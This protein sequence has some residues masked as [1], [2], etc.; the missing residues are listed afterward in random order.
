MAVG[1]SAEDVRLQPLLA[2]LLLV[3]RP[4]ILHERVHLRFLQPLE[5][6]FA[7]ARV[8]ELRQDGDEERAPVV[9]VDDAGE[10]RHLLVDLPLNE[11]A[12]G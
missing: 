7:E 9:A 3:V 5:V 8:E 6:V 12:I 2:Q 1:R 10:R 4:Q 11:P